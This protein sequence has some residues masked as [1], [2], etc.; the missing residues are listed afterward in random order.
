MIVNGWKVDGEQLKLSK[1]GVEHSIQPKQLLLLQYFIEH[2]NSLVSRDEIADNVWKDVIVADDSIYTSIAKLRKLLDPRGIGNLIK[3]VPKKGYVF[4]GEVSYEAQKPK[5]ADEAQANALQQQQHQ[6]SKSPVYT[7]A[8][9]MVILVVA[10]LAVMYVVEHNASNNNN[11]RIAILP[12]D[13]SSA[14]ATNDDAA[15]FASGLR[16]DISLFLTKMRGLSVVGRFTS[17]PLK[18]DIHPLTSA[19][20]R[21]IEYLLRGELVLD[22]ELFKLTLSLV[23]TYNGEITWTGN[24][25]SDYSTLFRDQFKLSS[26]VAN[27]LGYL[28]LDQDLHHFANAA[29]YKNYQHALRL[30]N[31]RQPNALQEAISE[32][33]SLE[34]TYPKDA[35]LS[36]QIGHAFSLLHFHTQDDAIRR[37]AKTNSL[38]YLDQAI[39]IDADNYEALVGKAMYHISI[40]WELDSALNHLLDAEQMRPGDPD[41]H[42][43]LGD[44]YRVMGPATKALFHEQL[45][46]DNDPRNPV[47]LL[48][49]AV[50][51]LDAN[52]LE[53]GT[54]LA[55]RA[56]SQYP[57]DEAAQNHY[58]LGLLLNQSPT[59]TELLS[60]ADNSNNN[61]FKPRVLEFFTLLGQGLNNKLTTDNIHPFE[62]NVKN[63]HNYLTKLGFLY[64]IAGDNTSAL[65]YFKQAIDAV[66]ANLLFYLPPK[67]I[68]AKH[69][70]LE[71]LLSNPLINNV[72]KYKTYQQQEL[73]TLFKTI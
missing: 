51:H 24:K 44:V 12:F 19:K 52:N 15:I 61:N 67:S 45:A 25:V 46:Y 50:A 8:I 72:Y 13:Y 26:E 37:E 22:D 65:S 69:P 66:D 42:N 2:P 41:I 31:S 20:N 23:N 70:E 38:K 16:S 14:S 43:Y 39:T 63:R 9:S 28:L 5:T 36:A 18:E 3:T 40:D 57:D 1:G 68:L 58:L 21:G 49:L 55:L 60:D 11:V 53:Q 17:D 30:I 64:F 71:V 32:L 73:L 56:M 48:E 6:T 35:R 34:Q 59:L 47:H 27:H 54:E 33:R 10:F 4:I 7:W 29:D 62:N